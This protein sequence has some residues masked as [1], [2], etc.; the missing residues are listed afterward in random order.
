MQKIIAISNVICFNCVKYNFNNFRYNLLALPF[1]EIKRAVYNKI[2]TE[3][4]NQITHFYG[5]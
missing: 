3:K 1:I 2:F 4:L 5:K